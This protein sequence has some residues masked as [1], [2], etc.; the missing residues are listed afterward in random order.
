MELRKQF[1]GPYRRGATILCGR[2][3]VDLA[4]VKTVTIIRTQRSRDEELEDLQ[5][6]SRRRVDDFNRGSQSVVLISPGHGYDADDIVEAGEDVTADYI[7]GP[8]GG[9]TLFG[10]MVNHPWTL[11]V[12]GGLIVPAL[13]WWLGWS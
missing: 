4:Q 11:T 3:V 13:V 7:S 10:S 12:L 9:P 6:K 1:M 5:E 2:E 8:P